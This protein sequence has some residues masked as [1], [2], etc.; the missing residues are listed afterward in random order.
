MGTN[1]ANQDNLSL[2]HQ[3]GDRYN[4]IVRPDRVFAVS[5]YLRTRW[6]PLLGAA[7]FWFV[8]ALRQRC[9]WNDRQ[10]WFIADKE[11]LARESGLS[12]RTVNRIIAAAD[13]PPDEETRDS[14]TAWFFDKTR[15]RRYRQ[16]VGRTVN[17]P[18]RYHVLLDDPLTPA[19]QYALD[20]YLARNQGDPS[21]E[22][23]LAL[24][25]ELCAHTSL[26]LY[27]ILALTQETDQTL[28]VTA[29]LLFTFDVVA[30]RCPMPARETALYAQIARAASELHNKLTRPEHVYVGN[31]YF[32]LQWLPTLGP[33]LSSV[34]VN[35]RARCYWDKRSG[36]LRDTCTANWADLA[37]EVGCTTRQLRNLR[38]HPD[39]ERFIVALDGG[40]TFKIQIPDPLTEADRERFVQE[41]GL[42]IDPETGQAGFTEFLAL[43]E[44]GKPE[45][46]TS[47]SKPSSCENP[48]E[49]ALGTEIRSEVLAPGN[50]KF[51]HIEGLKAEVLARTPGNSGTTVQVQIITPTFKGLT[52][53]ALDLTPALQR[54][55]QKLAAAART[56]LLHA[57]SIQS[58][59]LGKVLTRK[60]RCDVIVAWGI[61]A[62]TQ[63]GLTD[64]RAGYVYRRL[65]DGDPAPQDMLALAALSIA[66]W[67]A[68]E[69][70]HRESLFNHTTPKA[71]VP[72]YDL[73]RAHLLSVWDALDIDLGVTSEQT[74]SEM[75]VPP[76]ILSDL[77]TEREKITPTAKGWQIITSDLYRA[78]QLLTADRTGWKEVSVQVNFTDGAWLYALPAEWLALRITPLTAEQWRVVEQELQMV[79]SRLVFAQHWR[80]VVA[81]LGLC[82]PDRV[83]LG[84]SLVDERDWLEAWQKENVER[85]LCGVLG[86]KVQV[87]FWN[88]SYA[89]D[90]VA[91]VP[92]L[93]DL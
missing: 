58:P 83:L 60:P 15:R 73:W 40:H 81:P 66:D 16:Q 64:N 12:L 17:A 62:L 18:N 6:A 35:L 14:L 8:V 48:E 30:E 85:I 93:S 43:G 78:H 3:Y 45:I 33:V 1:P 4:E 77:L 22:G 86:R 9:Y 56:H 49:L 26:Q 75:L 38:T 80:R 79:M 21:P 13:H 61:Y 29:S 87:E 55:E 84:V 88:Y 90:S 7:R 68:L 37:R 34:V 69:E 54:D 11:T 72:A 82:A 42:E 20:Q 28:P 39:L 70:A 67:Q 91:E 24:L 63:A 19:D 74:I 52:A 44:A 92:L 36:E 50:Q 65:V 57:L 59:G 32:R 23:T 47:S 5:H 2:Q 76:K 46:M 53:T 71:D 41:A 10:D 89:G 31:Q 27:E 25:Q 51:W